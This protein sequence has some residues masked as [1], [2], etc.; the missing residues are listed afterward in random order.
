MS[1]FVG[2]IGLVD[3]DLEPVNIWTKETSLT[4][5]KS[6]NFIESFRILKCHLTLT[7]ATTKQYYEALISTNA[8]STVQCDC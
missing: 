8:S 4:M 3:S 2:F 1:D 7:T 5:R 6:G